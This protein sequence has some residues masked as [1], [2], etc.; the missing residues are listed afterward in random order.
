M[1]KISALSFA[2][3]AILLLIGLSAVNANDA[4]MKKILELY[5]QADTNGDGV[6]SDSEE[7]IL[8][9]QVLKR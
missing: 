5:P 6:V 9:R 2:G 1:K 4:I 7:A 8:S 3:F